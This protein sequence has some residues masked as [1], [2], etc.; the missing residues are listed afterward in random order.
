LI[1]PAD[2]QQP[3]SFTGP[4]SFKT[5]FVEDWFKGMADQRVT[6]ARPILGIAF[7]FAIARAREG[8]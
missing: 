6:G 7:A 4:A 1:F 2:G 5:S 8:L 3:A